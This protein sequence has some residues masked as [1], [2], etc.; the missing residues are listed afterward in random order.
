MKKFALG[1]LSVFM[2][3]GGVLLS[4]CDKK[5]SL[6]VSD[7]EVVL[8]TNY[9]NAENNKSKE[10]EV[11]IQNS[12]VGVNV[13]VMYG[14][15]CIDIERSNTTRKKANGKYAFKILTKED[16]N[17]GVAQLKVSS[18]EDSKKYEYI[19]VTVNTVIEDLKVTDHN[20]EEG[21]SDLFVVKGIDKE[22]VTTDYFDLLPIHANIVDIDWTFEGGEK[23][24][25][26][27]DKLCA[28]IVGS[29][30]KVS[31]DFSM[32]R[33]DVF[34][35]YVINTDIS[36][37]LTLEVLDDSTIRNYSVEDNVFYRNGVIQTTQA[38]V[39]LKRNNSNLS[40]VT[41][42]LVLDV[43]RNNDLRLSPVVYKRVNGQSVLVSSEEYEQYFTF[44]Y[45][46]RNNESEGT[47]TYNISI[48]A[49]DHSAK[50]I[51]GQFEVYL[52]VDY[53]GYNYSVSTLQT[54]L[55]L[56]I[57]YSATIVELSDENGY[58]INNTFQDVFSSYETALG[59]QVNTIIGPTD[60]AID[61]RYF[62]ITLDTRQTALSN[63]TLNQTNPV[64]DIA[65]FFLEDGTPLQFTQSATGSS[66]FVS[67]A[68]E[69]GT[70]VFVKGCDIFD[71]LETVE[72]K[73][74]ARSNTSVNTSLYFTFFKIAED[75]TMAVESAGE[76]ALEEVTFL[77]SSVYSDRTLDFTVKIS[78]IATDSGLTLCNDEVN[79][80]E[81]SNITLLSK[82]EE[83]A[84]ESFVVVNFS[85][86][87]S[88][89]NFAD[90]STFW[91]EHITG[92]KSEEFKVETF[93]PIESVTIQN[94]DKS[95]S[96]VYIDNSEAQSYVVVNDLIETD[97]TKQSYSLSKLML[98]A[99]TS[100]PIYTSFQ[101][102]TLTSNGISYRFMS[103]EQLRIY[104]SILYGINDSAELDR[105]ANEAIADGDLSLVA[106]SN[107]FIYF[108]DVDAGYFS[109]TRDMLTVSNRPFKG[110]VAVLVEG[111]DENHEAVTLARFFAL[112]SFY[113]V[114][115]LSSN[116]RTTLLYT[117]DTLSLSDINR[118]VVDVSISMRQDDNIPTYSDSL[119]YFTFTSALQDFYDVSA[120]KTMWKNDF[121]TISNVT[122]ANNGKNL[123]FR[124]TARSTNLQTSVKDVLR[125]V[126][127]DEHG[128]EKVS[129]IQIE[130]RNVK[131]LESVQWV[132]RTA[133][134]QIYLNLTTANASEKNFTISTS[135]EPSDANDI[136]L[137]SVYVATSGS[138]S[139]IRI[140][141]SSVGQIFNVNINT[142]RGGRGS[143]YLLPND[144]IKNVDGFNHVLVYK[145]VENEDGSI[146]EIPINI[147]LSNLGAMYEEIIAGS[148]D[149]SNYFYNNEG[150]KV[151]YSNIILK[152]D[153]TIA[154][155][156]SEGTAIRV[157]NQ[158][159]LEEI[160]RAK[161]YRV[162]NDITL[163]GWKSFDLFS[164]MI[165]G[166]D[167][168]VTLKFTNG[169]E[170]FVN[171][172]NGTL[173]DLIF[174]GEV[175]VGS[176]IDPVSNA[177][178]IANQVVSYDGKVGS[179]ENCSVD[180]YYSNA[181]NNYYGSRLNAYTVS[182]VGSYAVS[183]V[184]MIAGLNE[185]TIENSFIYGGSI[186][187]PQSAYVGGLVGANNGVVRGSGFEFYKFEND[188][189]NCNTITTGG[190]VGGLVGF[191]G[192]TS[193]VETSYAYA[194]ALPQV[195]TTEEGSS[196][197][198]SVSNIINAQGVVGVLAGG[199]LNGARFSQVFGFLGDVS[200]G[201]VTAGNDQ[202]VTVENS[203]ISYYDGEKICS[204]IFKY[205]TYSFANDEKVFVNGTETNWTTLTD[206]D[207]EIENANLAALN[208]DE[209][210][211]DLGK[212]DSEIN[213][214]YIYLRNV[215]QSTAVDLNEVHVENSQGEYDERLRV[216]NSG[217][218]TVGSNVYETG[219]LFMFN[220]INQVVDVQ[221]KAMLDRLN[222]ISVATLF[223]I[224]ADQARGLLLTS[225]SRNISLSANSIRILSTSI[226][227]TSTS[228]FEINVHSKMDFTQVK[229]FKFV[230][231]NVLP[232][233]STMIDGIALRD[234][235]MILLQT[236]ASRTIVYNTLSSL[237]LNG[238]TPYALNK[239]N[240]TINY[241]YVGGGSGSNHV[242]LTRSSNSLVL[243]GL[244]K[245][246]NDDR[247]SI[248]TNLSHN[249]LSGNA[250][251]SNYAEAVNDKISRTFETRVYNGAKRLEVTNANNMIVRPSEYATFDVVMETDEES[252]GLVFSLKYDQ[253]DVDAEVDGN[254]ARFDVDSNLALEVS[255]ATISSVETAGVLQ[256]R[257]KVFVRVSDDT[258]HLVE[259]DYSDLTLSVNASSQASNTTYLRNISLK[260]E[261]Q[262]IEDFSI[263]T[264]AIERR[265]IRNSILYLTPSSQILNTISPAS[266]AI[267]SV[268]VTP[269]FAKMTH[270]TLTYEVAGNA[271][272]TVGLSKLVYNSL[273]GYYVNSSSSTVVTNGIRVNLTEADKTGDGLF[274]FRLYVS[275]S[276]AST[277]GLRLVTTFYN[278]NEV[279]MVGSQTITVDYMQDA[280]VRVNNA[281]TY[282]LAKGESATVTVRVGIDQDLAD[283]YLQN[284]E[285][286]IS[287][288][289]PTVE[290]VGNYKVY[291]AEIYAGVDAKLVG[292]KD[293][294]T[295]YV[296]ASVRRVLNNIEEEKTSRAALCLVDFSID[297]NGIS[298]VGSGNK[299]MYNGKSY[300]VF[301]AYI[302][303]SSE[304]HF[305]YPLLPEEYNYDRNDAEAVRAVAQLTERRNQFL[306]HNYYRDA[307][308]DYSINCMRNQDTG[309]YDVITLKQQLWSGTS[310]AYMTKI[311]N[312]DR[313]TITQNDYFSITEETL[314]DGST[315]LMVSGKRA[316]T[317][318][319]KL[320][321]YV[322]YQGTEIYADYYF[323]IVVEVWTDEESPTQITTGAELVDFATNSE[324]A[325]DYILMN[326]IVLSD[327][328]PLD[329]TL[330]NSLDGNGYTIHLNS[331]RMGTESSVRLA[332]FDTVTA[333]TTLKNVRVNIYNGGQIAVNIRQYSQV[334]IAGFALANE[335]V[336]Y[337]CEVVSYFDEEYQVSKNTGNSG[338]VVKYTNGANTTPIPLTVSMGVESRVS[339]FVLEN[340][341]SIMNSRVGGESFKHVVEID[342]TRYLKSQDLDVFYLE[343]QGEVSGFVNANSGYI[344]A[345][346][347]K[348]IQIDNIMEYDS[349]IT[350]GFV[351]RNTQSIQNSYVEG[352]GGATEQ[353][354]DSQEEKEI[355]YNNLSNISSLGVIS[356]FV[357]ENNSL[358]KN[359]YSNIAIENSKTKGSMV[360][361]FVY[362]NNAGAEVTLCY[363]ACEIAK[364]DITQ[365][366]FSGVD[367]FTNSLNNGTIS[368]SYFY[369][370]SRT[371]D[372]IQSKVTQSAIAVYDVDQKNSFY[373]FSF[374]SEEGAYN[375]IW[376][377]RDNGKITLVSANQIAISNRYAVT[378]GRI[379]SIFYSRSIRDIDTLNYVDL[380]YGGASNPIILRNAT[381]FAKA[382]GKATTTEVSSYKEFY[383]D[384][385]VTGRYRIV[386]NIDMTDI[387]QDAEDEGSVKLTTTQKVFRGLLDG[388]G[389]TISNI[390]LGSSE[391][392]ENF[393]LFARLSGAVIMN[394]DLTVES[395]HN[396]QANIVGVLAGTAVDSRILAI[397]L[398]PTES[399]SEGE[400]TAV[401]G[402]N[403]VG[404]VV[405]ML[406][407]ESYLSDIS[408]SNV[409]V[410]SEGFT[411]GKQIN[412][413]KQ[414]IEGDG[415]LTKSLREL[416]E[417]LDNG[418][419]LSGNVSRLSYA[420][421]IAGY[422][423]TYA[424]RD[425]GYV[426]YS[427][428]REM[429]DYDIV[430]VR[431][432]NS[433]N[434]YAEVAGGLFGYV[435]K[436]TLIYD[437]KL[438][439]NQNQTLSTQ[440]VSPSY[441]ISKNLFAGGLVGENYGGLFAV[442]ATYEESL[443][444][445]IETNEN[446]YYNQNT[447]AEKGQLSIFSYTPNDEGYATRTN[448]PLFIGGL[449]GYMG[450]GYIFVGQSKL[451]VIS[452]TGAI[453]GGVVGLSGVSSNRYDLN[454]TS[455]RKAINTL[456]YEVYAS[457][458]VYSEGGVAAGIIGALEATDS[459]TGIIAMKNVMAMNYYSY[460]GFALTGDDAS[461]GGAS[462]V[463]NSDNHYMLVGR[464]YQRRT[465]SGNNYEFALLDD[466]SRLFS[467][468][469][470]INSINDIVLNLK[471]GT[472]PNTVM[473]SYTVGGYKEITIGSATAILNEFG[474]HSPASDTKKPAGPGENIDQKPSVLQESIL[475]AQHIA[476][477]D[478]ET[479]S[480][481]YAR[482]RSYFISNGW[483]EKYWTHLQDHLFPDIVLL[484]KVSIKFWDVDNTAEILQD[485]NG[486]SS[487]IVVRG[488]ARHDDENC[489]D[490][491]DI[492]LT[493]AIANAPSDLKR[494]IENFSGRLVSYATYMNSQ[495]GGK[496]T[497]T[498]NENG[499]AVG[500][501]V[502]IILKQ[503]L[504]ERISGNASIE[505]LT[506]YM[507]PS[508]ESAGFSLI[509]NEAESA[510]LR[511]I[512][513]VVN[514][515][516]TISAGLDSLHTDEGSY[517]TVG[518][519]TGLATSTSFY[520]IGI[521][522]RSGANLVLDDK[523]SAGEGVYM[524]LLAGRIRQASTHSQMSISGVSI[525]RANGPTAPAGEPV[526]DNSPIDISFGSKKL[527]SKGQLFAGIYAGE[528]VKASGSAT[529]SVGVRQ[530]NNVN[531]I[532]G[533]DTAETGNSA[534]LQ[535]AYIGGYAGSLSG[536]DKVELVEGD[537]DNRNGTGISIYQ[538]CSI[539]TLYAGLAFGQS[540][541]GIQFS[542]DRVPNAWLIGRVIQRNG[543]TGKANIGS[544][545]GN[546]QNSIT[547]SGLRVKFDVAHY[548]MFEVG[549]N[550]LD[551][552]N[553][554]TIQKKFENNV[555]A[556]NK[557]QY[558]YD[559]L[560]PFVVAE[561]D[562]N[563][564]NAFGGVVG[565][566][567]GA[568]K[569]TGTSTVSGNIIVSSSE[570]EGATYIGGILGEF[571]GANEVEFGGTINNDV[572]I[573]S[574]GEKTYVGGAVGRYND[575]GN[576]TSENSN[577]GKFI[578]GT[579]NVSTVGSIK[580][581]GQ[582]V[583]SG[584][585]K[586]YFGGAVGQL[587][588]R[589]TATVT[590]YSFGGSLKVLVVN[591]ADVNVGGVVGTYKDN[592]AST[593]T[594]ISSTI[595]NSVAFG[596]VFVIYPEYA[597]VDNNDV[598]QKDV[599]LSH[600]AFGGIV[601]VAQKGLSIS[602]CTSLLTNFNRGE[603]QSNA[604]SNVGAIVGQNADA[605]PQDFGSG[606]VYYN[607]NK[608]SSV[609][610]MTIQEQ[611]GN[612]DC[613]YGVGTFSGY[614]TKTGAEVPSDDPEA[615]SGLTTSKNIL[616]GLS[617][618]VENPA[619]GHK[620]NPYS[621]EIFDGR[622][623]NAEGVI[624]GSF[625]NIKW[626][627]I[628]RDLQNENALVGS[629]ASN[630]TNIAVVG[631]GLNI[632]VNLDG[633]TNE[634]E[635]ESAN[636]QTNQ[637]NAVFEGGI[638]DTMGLEYNTNTS[639]N[640]TPNFNMISGIV[641]D[642]NVARNITI[643]DNVG[644][645]VNS[646]GGVVGRMTGNS[647]VYGVGVKGELSVGGNTT[648]SLGGLVGEMDEGRIDQ[649]YVDA[650]IIYRGTTAGYVSG[651]ANMGQLSSTINA[652]YSSGKIISYV[653]APIYTFA[654]AL[655]SSSTNANQ[656]GIRKIK[657]CYSITQV[658]RNNVL[659]NVVGEDTG[660]YF[661]AS[662]VSKAGQVL[663][664]TAEVSDSDSDLAYV[665]SDSLALSYSD[666]N[667]YSG[668]VMKAGNY[669]TN[670]QGVVS[671]ITKEGSGTNAVSVEG[672]TTWYFSRLTNYG[673]ASH[674]FGYLKNSTTYTCT[675]LKD[676]EDKITG[677]EYKPVAYDDLLANED[678]FSSADGGAWYFGI[679]SV[680][681][682]KQMIETVAS[683]V[684]TNGIITASDAYDKNYK[685]VLRYGFSLDNL[686]QETRNVGAP[687]KAFV[688]DGNGNTI[689]FNNQETNFGLFQNVV[690]EIRNL[691]LINGNI[692]ADCDSGML[693]SKVNGSINNITAIGNISV[694]SNPN[695]RAVGGIVANMEGSA[696][697]LESLVNITNTSNRPLVIGG[698][699]G[700][701]QGSSNTG[702]G[703][704]DYAS[705]TG[706]L[707]NSTTATNSN[708]S[709]RKLNDVN[710]N[711][712]SVNAQ[713]ASMKFGDA[714]DSS[715]TGRRAGTTYTLRAITGGV[716]GY[717]VKGKVSNSYNANSVLSNFAEDRDN[718]R[719]QHVVSGGI[720]GYAEGSSDNKVEI[721]DCVNASLV[722]AGNY[723][724]CDGISYAGGI[725]GY[726]KYLQMTDSVN[727]G[728]VQAL[729]RVYTSAS[730]QEVSY[731]SRI[732]KVD[733]DFSDYEAGE[734]DSPKDLL[735]KITMIY[736]P[737]KDRLVNAYGLGYAESGSTID[738]TN[739]TTTNNVK[740]DGNIG[741]ITT[742]SYLRFNRNE[743]LDGDGSYVASF[744]TSVKAT[745][746]DSSNSFSNLSISGVDSYGFPT[747]VY[748]ID[749]ITRRLSD[750]HPFRNYV[751]SKV[752][753]D[754]TTRY[755]WAWD[756]YDA[757]FKAVIGADG[758]VSD[759][760]ADK[761]YESVPLWGSYEPL[762]TSFAA[763]QYSMIATTSYYSSSILSRTW[764]GQNLN[765]DGYDAILQHLNTFSHMI[766]RSVGGGV[767]L[768]NREDS[769]NTSNSDSNVRK[770]ENTLYSIGVLANERIGEIDKYIED[771]NN[772]E[773]VK[774]LNISGNSVGVAKT[775][776]NV[777]TI[778]TPTSAEIN[779]VVF[780]LSGYEQ[781]DMG[782]ITK[783]SV[784][785]RGS[786]RNPQFAEYDIYKDMANKKVYV[787]G[788]SGVS[789][790]RPK[791]YFA[792]GFSS[793]AITVGLSISSSILK[794][795]LSDNNST[796]NETTGV[797]VI[798][799]TKP[800]F[801]DKDGQEGAKTKLS[802][803]TSIV[804]ATLGDKTGLRAILNA[805][806]TQL[807]ISG[808][809]G[810]TSADINEKSVIVTIREQYVERR[811]GAEVIITTNKSSSSYNGLVNLTESNF[812]FNFKNYKVEE[813]RTAF[814]E[815]GGGNTLSIDNFLSGLGFSRDDVFAYTFSSSSYSATVYWDGTQ[816]KFDASNGV[817][818]TSD[819]TN[820]VV[821]GSKAL[822]FL[823]WATTQKTSMYVG[824]DPNT[825]ISPDENNP[826][827]V[828]G[829]IRTI[830][831][832]LVDLYG[833]TA[834][835]N[836]DFHLADIQGEALSARYSGTN[837]ENLQS[838]S[839][840]IDVEG[841]VVGG[842]SIDKFKSVD[843][844][845]DYTFTATVKTVQE[846]MAYQLD[847]YRQEN[848]AD[849]LAGVNYFG[850]YLGGAGKSLS[851]IRLGDRLVLSRTTNTG[852]VEPFTIES[853]D[854]N[855][856]SP[857][858][859]LKIA[860]SGSD[861]EE[862]SL[863]Y[864]ITEGTDRIFNFRNQKFVSTTREQETR[865]KTYTYEYKIW[866]NG[867]VEVDFEQLDNDSQDIEVANYFI[868]LPMAISA[869]N[870]TSGVNSV[871][872]DSFAAGYYSF[873]K[874]KTLRRNSDGQ[875]T[876]SSIVYRGGS[877]AEKVEASALDSCTLKKGA[878]SSSHEI[879]VD[880]ISV[881]FDQNSVK[882][883][884]NNVS[885]ISVSATY[886]LTKYKNTPVGLKL[887]C[888]NATS[889]LIDV[890]SK[891]GVHTDSSTITPIKGGLPASAGTN[892]WNY[893]TS[894]TYEV[895][896]AADVSKAAG[897]VSSVG[898]ESGD[899]A[900]IILLASDI[901]MANIQGAISKSIIGS[902]YIMRFVSSGGSMLGSVSGTI[903]NV[904][905]AGTN[906]GD[907]AVA[908]LANDITS[909]VAGAK[910]FGSIRN[911][912]AGT[913]TTQVYTDYISGSDIDLVNSVS[914][915]GCNASQGSDVKVELKAK[916]FDSNDRAVLVAGDALKGAN[917][918]SYNVLSDDSTTAMVRA[919]D[920]ATEAV[921]GEDGDPGNVG[922]S[923]TI[924]KKEGV[925]STPSFALGGFSSIGGFGGDGA[926]GR[927]NNSNIALGGGKGGAAGSAASG[928]LHKTVESFVQYKGNSGIG[929][930]G[931]IVN[932][933]EA[934][935]F[936]LLTSGNGGSDTA[937]GSN[938]NSI[939]SPN[940]GSSYDCFFAASRSSYAFADGH[941]FGTRSAWEWGRP[942]DLTLC[943]EWIDS[944]RTS[945]QNFRSDVDV[946]GIGGKTGSN[947][948]GNI[949]EISQIYIYSHIR[950]YSSIKNTRVDNAANWRKVS[951]CSG[952]TVN[953]AG[954]FTDC[955][956]TVHS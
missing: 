380:S 756:H 168:T 94:A 3:L 483:D 885:N 90:V 564:H 365:M 134:N 341:S 289:T 721:D 847:I 314:I 359:S 402:H 845:F 411:E 219:V 364:K 953:G 170:S 128:F 11:D 681:K 873:V 677:Y 50:N 36:R 211:W 58:S 727:D 603:L 258:K 716:V 821:N 416:V 479:P 485:M 178:F 5:V 507:T 22:L 309:L 781:V 773:G 663:N 824:V 656:F 932:N 593:E 190:N 578:I 172:L 40:S 265:Q 672:E 180:V 573:Y 930:F 392:F 791:L 784:K 868:Y 566:S 413:N 406:F 592:S 290:V 830:F 56:D 424:S 642:L 648:I 534:E 244:L 601:G 612:L 223:G 857:S 52:Q 231:M 616:D 486:S 43:S 647:F 902:N 305:N 450:G 901:S 110:F 299:R 469:Y 943:Q 598:Y 103:F 730:G 442:S 426:T 455:E 419:S 940:H 242:G 171:N 335:G 371:D 696:S 660:V 175:T 385:D 536:A 555:Q 377:M 292:G 655:A 739:S 788:L 879:V 552:G 922:G 636:G 789:G 714:S 522:F 679:P 127:L 801:A 512:N 98:E 954:G 255:W 751:K 201:F 664:G 799:L 311:Y 780:D 699:V 766:D 492:D 327:Y 2:I 51:F 183:N 438:S 753:S 917:G 352:L 844:S 630:L 584:A 415:D 476:N 944:V 565:Y 109:I 47:K 597:K 752:E 285:S 177:G 488:R 685:F 464:I 181:D 608:Y 805:A 950:V 276:F 839:T 749:T 613:G 626:V 347:V 689:D 191:A 320:T 337:N 8:F 550:E 708:V 915:I 210:I 64:G 519:I 443:Q 889:K 144:M 595:S 795:E 831:D 111:Y 428:S 480:S 349:S 644:S 927:F 528:I 260:V 703:L 816:F 224:S 72:F 594:Q 675:E 872:W 166:N 145:Y 842:M 654:N 705:N 532:L 774:F 251:F 828:T 268:S 829:I 114:R 678:T 524:G 666:S 27:D 869:G 87:L 307:E 117:A 722:G 866:E 709:V 16:K 189:G 316:G 662:A 230:I 629:L 300:D 640:N 199:S 454:F 757:L 796:F 97:A 833:D 911:I 284:N 141:T 391:S 600:Y 281:T 586:L 405:G 579:D 226:S 764:G 326:D 777:T 482:M 883:I 376:E 861:D 66:I 362:R 435:G 686:N 786:V 812:K 840:G 683:N 351:V 287:L 108:D 864:S 850:G 408:V 26:I 373:G 653:N 495:E 717:V 228:E 129:E 562:T 849:I 313:G 440:G 422:V 339:G 215:A 504:F 101:S 900:E 763:N 825:A 712:T 884:R 574:G 37:K 772:G 264:Y 283:L 148:D 945:S 942:S 116:V 569:L 382:T 693:A 57:T 809:N 855:S 321:T 935:D 317:Q 389:F 463:Y 684:D 846:N 478:F 497:G 164:G 897:S 754:G 41:G 179:I 372:T 366:Q 731:K 167:E 580:Y 88:A 157:Y 832:G 783:A 854:M 7:K 500:E 23:E 670:D 396:A 509:S 688:F 623:L 734:S 661:K 668:K 275:S 806:K 501:R 508:S 273:Y 713:V 159:D 77:S 294:G 893:N 638:A 169:S 14:Q 737:S 947:D 547:I 266:D 649:C 895:A 154:D 444:S 397:T 78:G 823:Q 761:R 395:V 657:D 457:G 694:V 96:N 794:F 838:T 938:G 250:S 100:L 802:N 308:V 775:S 441:I 73:F 890:D 187:A 914:M 213:F 217:D 516:M 909:S 899:H 526:S 303:D 473:G 18:I 19:N 619:I 295:F 633:T 158:G 698:V 60:V 711:Y 758:S 105:L 12:K 156:N 79:G 856:D 459:A 549:E 719:A 99:G 533:V 437:A 81:Y 6:S 744:E 418:I 188:E 451:N 82:S 24:L 63:L 386:N 746:S 561:D 390:S 820:V 205:V 651:V 83:G 296:C 467:D 499:G 851:G 755:G 605:A 491:Q 481:A 590:G 503:S 246:E 687:T 916:D 235:Q 490:F 369:N 74:E 621:I 865:S 334:E 617:N 304:L 302:N 543:T 193:V 949:R 146:T 346:F 68:I 493:G 913:A 62:R 541:A 745:T 878:L 59:Y 489:Y 769:V 484:P 918:T 113:S 355:I 234:N 149:I 614:T 324:E 84:E 439:I 421:A 517:R 348:D 33:V 669:S 461:A 448:R 407:G 715:S 344:S 404:G 387:A 676:D 269:Q 843:V 632:E 502:G 886:S 652:T 827:S 700:V 537:S 89:Y 32:N 535:D 398:T 505:G 538:N 881:G 354:G 381:D 620:L 946:R 318:L 778:L 42:T 162:M 910:L 650:D 21:K 735:L 814:P 49:I 462:S 367:D 747:R 220:P 770:D 270:F 819:G 342:G 267:V 319:M 738:N 227:G 750:S 328:T 236:G 410:S 184:G 241:S 506:F 741:E 931:R 425:E 891:N 263:S 160:D 782:S 494:T 588:T 674:G 546:S 384:T 560:K 350:A 298:V 797:L 436:S 671:V 274:Y 472:A 142:T 238:T 554:M 841:L 682:F 150:E 123:T 363:A 212:T 955:G 427:T 631:N 432:S 458:D 912:A 282:L 576:S 513:I 531:L 17:S 762:S 707:K 247:T 102:A 470:I 30:L 515:S 361:G 70:K 611:D 216:L 388:N 790:S 583:V 315:R 702:E 808:L 291:T 518:L 609:V 800:E 596:D 239:D 368:L 701:L 423:D 185:G 720:V 248:Y 240:F 80:F 776:D 130:I 131:R 539:N 767:L 604:A 815:F 401:Q 121:Y 553:A 293:S 859:S 15:D 297:T 692:E 837:F 197:D 9:E 928:T 618:L 658:E 237:Y 28:E 54:K 876:S 31:N 124:I 525:G 48:D 862:E 195:K 446:S 375:G 882:F 143:L 429:S 937:A 163:N 379:T 277:S 343:G 511:N 279:L 67:R 34:A 112:E 887:K 38:T 394:L 906:S 514:S 924:E 558:T 119:D 724:N 44:D 787:R 695:V 75:K 271:V 253:V 69:T 474:F 896:W 667:K 233:L 733:G 858:V 431:V 165:F 529:V 20:S 477:D 340:N 835:D 433:V 447:G 400:S 152:I 71:Q 252:D 728:P 107:A 577:V 232:T 218:K 591:G 378:N 125:I 567:T 542:F 93:V 306:N 925:S 214:G 920:S 645:K 723:K 76:E 718:G 61:D 759:E 155:G 736:N 39:S 151:Y 892:K 329:T 798:D 153:I 680:G 310:E 1:I 587:L 923:A 871:R 575:G 836:G 393:G 122:L 710:G 817:T 174:T 53:A 743:M 173:K 888:G 198:Y 582:V 951:W 261:T 826:D 548:D 659:E 126:Y 639:A 768:E 877:A 453:A 286:K 894:G 530:I 147:P 55:V 137:T 520:N 939:S 202:Y 818:I 643:P 262:K 793:N 691:R 106:N 208:L 254:F 471:D 785:F 460:S 510:L 634:S 581:S 742:V 810:F 207:S 456:Y 272:G 357:Y 356:G 345:S 257:Y 952:E 135:V 196:L 875:I 571:S 222:T 331:F 607:E 322:N 870:Y 46:E 907:G 468:F 807:T 572:N 280:V 860:N 333:N 496:I 905:F 358:V 697:K 325:G 867:I 540:N 610:S 449:V 409:D 95:S 465:V 206:K 414:Y 557:N 848:G 729:G 811:T 527:N 690:G 221:E 91:F 706:I 919:E 908:L 133:D 556:I 803:A 278:G 140:S 85:V 665:P 118:S 904:T 139:D 602:K 880:L 399:Q 192:V 779:E 204:D 330:I 383:T 551:D 852:S 374:S 370:D 10:I 259:E 45:S 288:T 4:G 498:V 445:I 115:F 249:S 182:D 903:R 161:Y 765:F 92:K 568:L 926:H 834:S 521:R 353:V 929:G 704:V 452:H 874:E 430:T 336:I 936:T 523:V 559:S 323:L 726:A 641:V 606:T 760:F 771:D 194:Y 673:Y 475:K 417:D 570:S 256:N 209:T 86:S 545:V 725:V 624:T 628:K 615:N 245:H 412:E 544:I 822:D 933:G 646:F 563:V 29:T 338:L 466:N 948:N 136:G 635:T 65:Q 804:S 176:T 956:G 186:N 863:S 301:H 622:K 740:N 934:H 898:E 585:K 792:D 589:G 13:E 732:D 627:S 138:S 332:L 225:D 360:A 132:N 637:K 434:I 312:E 420:G 487:T 200:R 921:N 243:S 625:N 203:Y 813:N 229:T 35:S 748:G 25:Y 104:L 120:G 941:G 853:V 599:L 403:V